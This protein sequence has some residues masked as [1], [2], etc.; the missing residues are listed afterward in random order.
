MFP[1]DKRS[2]KLYPTIDVIIRYAT[3]RHRT[4][5]IVLFLFRI[6]N[7]TCMSFLF[8]ITLVDLPLYT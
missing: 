5:I 4:I 6:L 3:I 1:L 7:L 2:P 8:E